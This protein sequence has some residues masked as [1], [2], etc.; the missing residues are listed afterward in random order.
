MPALADNRSMAIL[1]QPRAFSPLRSMFA[2]A[3]IN[4]VACALIAML[5]WSI[6]PHKG[7]AIMLGYSLLIGNLCWLFIDGS[8]ALV[9][10]WRWRMRGG[11]PEWPGVTWMAPVVVLGT[12][13]GYSIGSAIADRLFAQ[14]SPSLGDSAPALLISVIAA[15][16][17]VYVY[18]A[19]ERLHSQQ[20]AA[21]AAERQTAEMQLKLLQSQLEPHMLFNTLANLRVLIG[22][23]PQ[24]AQVMLDQL[25]A[26]LRTT[27]AA[28]RVDRHPLRVEFDCVRDYLALMGVRMGARLQVQLEL[29][30]DARELPVPPMLL[31][32]LVENAIKHGLEPQLAGGCIVVSAERRGDTLRL[33]VRDDGVGLAATPMTG[34][35]HFGLEQVRARLATLFGTSAALDVRAA[36]HGGTEAV[37]TLPLVAAPS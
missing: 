29:P 5:L 8:R 9:G 20:L 28:T 15:S 12:A 31:Q 23:E 25:I 37:L 30:A 27:L 4:Q 34:G 16:I 26:F 24:R 14:R 35:T 3:A 18:Y 19:R 22:V 10:R 17:I 1:P 21:E 13:L 33:A 32:P 2:R 11:N 36:T 6:S 7:P